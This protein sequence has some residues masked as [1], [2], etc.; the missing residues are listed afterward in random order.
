MMIRLKYTFKDTLFQVYMYLA[1]VLLLES[2]KADYDIIIKP[3]NFNGYILMLDIFDSRN[4][5]H[6]Q[7]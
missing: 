4:V 2:T 6:T 7:K 1:F 3:L 5:K